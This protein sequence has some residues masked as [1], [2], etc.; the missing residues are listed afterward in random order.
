MVSVPSWQPS[1]TG[2]SL[3]EYTR[4]LHNSDLTLSPVG[5]NSEC[6]RVYEALAYGSIPVIEDVQTVGDCATSAHRLLKEHKA[7][8]VFIDSWKKLP[9]ILQH[10]KT[11]S[12]DELVQRRHQAIS[13]YT[14]FKQTMQQKFVQVVQK[15]FFSADVL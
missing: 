13:W 15:H 2:A 12:L 5:Q 4:A 14:N 1:E 6:Y 11:M 10:E 3:D 8:V 9:D 7:P